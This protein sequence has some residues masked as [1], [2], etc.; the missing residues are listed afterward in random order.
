[1]PCPDPQSYVQK[2]LRAHDPEG[3]GGLTASA[4]CAVLERLNVGLNEDE[5][6]KVHEL[7]DCAQIRLIPSVL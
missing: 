5:K 6:H 3:S 2:V 7:Q 1:M 4:L